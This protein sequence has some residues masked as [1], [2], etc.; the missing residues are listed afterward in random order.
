MDYNTYQ[1]IH[2]YSVHWR[3]CCR[4]S[5]CKI[6]PGLTG[7]PT[8]RSLCLAITY[9]V[10]FSQRLPTMGEFLSS[11]DVQ[12]VMSGAVGPEKGPTCGLAFQGNL[13]LNCR[14]ER[15]CPVPWF[16]CGLRVHIQAWVQGGDAG[17]WCGTFKRWD[18]VGSDCFWGAL[19]IEIDVVLVRGWL[20]KSTSDLWLVL[21]FPS[22]HEI[23]LCHLQPSWCSPEMTQPEGPHQSWCHAPWAFS[24]QNCE[25]R[26][27][28][29]FIRCP[30][31][32]VLL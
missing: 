18:S 8:F 3:Q 20:W 12:G 29:F 11:R 6:V 10:A 1:C 14:N 24:L 25:P 9:G 2:F 7:S 21:W 15:P 28:V 30:V 5:K 22:H 27:P 17:R 31:S 16:G 32:N 13:S 23:S 4:S 26:K 19:P